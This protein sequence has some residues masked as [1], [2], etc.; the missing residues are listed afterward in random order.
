MTSRAVSPVAWASMS[1]RTS[2][3]V[4]SARRP[5]SKAVLA[6]FVTHIPRMNVSSSAAGSN[7]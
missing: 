4:R 7:R 6:G 1:H 5:R 3:S 2:A